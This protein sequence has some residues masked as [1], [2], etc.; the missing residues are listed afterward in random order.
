MLVRLGTRSSEEVVQGPEPQGGGGWAEKKGTPDWDRDPA[1][2]SWEL[3]ARS[4]GAG[5]DG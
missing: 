2:R 1:W 4:P 3:G 5:H